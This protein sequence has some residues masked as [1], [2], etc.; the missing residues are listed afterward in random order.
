MTD[1]T[2]MGPEDFGR[3]EY[4]P[5]QLHEL[6]DMNRLYKQWE[7]S[8]PPPE[9]IRT[10]FMPEGYETDPGHPTRGT[11][12]R[13]GSSGKAYY[14]DSAEDEIRTDPPVNSAQYS[15]YFKAIPTTLT[16][17]DIYRVCDLFDV[18]GGPVEHAIKKLLCA[19]RRG[20][21]DRKRDITEAM[22][23]LQRAIEMITEDEVNA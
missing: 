9:P 4:A 8:Q 23:S 2:S 12:V 18:G 19:G 17:I 7:Q 15:H 1:N 16:H 21:K 20:S 11:G 13:F 22:N 5:A 3:D 6:E 14:P 10:G